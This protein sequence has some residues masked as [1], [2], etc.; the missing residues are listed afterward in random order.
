MQESNKE[1]FFNRFLARIKRYSLYG[2]SAVASVVTIG[3]L[4]EKEHPDFIENAP[5]ESKRLPNWDSKTYEEL[6]RLSEEYAVFV[7]TTESEHSI[8]K[9]EAEKKFMDFVGRYGP[10]IKIISPAEDVGF[11]GRMHKI[12]LRDDKRAHYEIGNTIVYEPKKLTKDK[13]GEWDFST[14]GIREF[15]AEFS[16]HLNHDASITRMIAYTE[17]LAEKKLDQQAMYDDIY[18]SEYQAHSITQNAIAEYLSPINT[19]TF[20]EIYNTYQAYYRACTEASNCEDNDDKEYL[21]YTY[22]FNK[23]IADVI[24]N[25]EIFIANLSS[26]R[27]ILK[28]L[29]RDNRQKSNLFAAI[30]DTYPLDKK[31]D[32]AELTKDVDMETVDP[33]YFHFPKYNP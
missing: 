23:K 21:L 28:N 13:K 33:T 14:S 18:S 10:D 26:L 20:P 1:E 29:K 11:A 32:Y 6:K 19:Y 15:I 17:D 2:L 7:E 8:T 24:N 4:S 31:T 3:H 16:H 22:V 12:L 27:S 30:I 9:E 5:I 25:K